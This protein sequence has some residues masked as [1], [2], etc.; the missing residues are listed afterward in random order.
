MIKNLT[1]AALAFGTISVSF[2]GSSG[3]K[4]LDAAPP[5][6]NV[7]DH[8]VVTD[9]GSLLRQP[10]AQ[11]D[12]PLVQNAR[13]SS[14]ADRIEQT[15]VAAPMPPA[16]AD[17]TEFAHFD[18]FLEPGQTSTFPGSAETIGRDIGGLRSWMADHNIG[19]RAIASASFVGNLLSTGQP[20]SPQRYNGQRPTLQLAAQNFNIAWGL[21]EFGLD[22]TKI[23]FGLNNTFTSYDA[24]GLDTTYIRTLAI[25]QSFFNGRLTIKAGITPNY[26]EYIGFY[27]G[28]SP[29][30]AAGIAGLLP[31]QAGLGADPANVP[32]IN[33]TAYGANGSYI[34]AGVQRSTSP[35][36]LN[37]EVRQRHGI[38]INIKLEDAGPLYIAEFGIR[39]PASAT[40]KQIWLRAGGFY[41]DS[42]YRRFDGEGTRSN[43][44]FYAL[45]DRQVTQPDPIVPARGIY[46]GA[47]AYLNPKS[48]NIST[49]SYEVRTF[50]IGMLPSRPR[51]TLALRATWTKFSKDARAANERIG[52]YA[53]KD[54]LN[55]TLSYSARVF[56]G[57]YVVPALSYIDHPSFVGDF[58]RALLT[59]VALVALF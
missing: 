55:V 8:L 30:L 41:N 38:G 25:Y 47:S 50:T 18:T 1:R 40:G 19:L 54:Q 49:Q 56:R 42:N 44:S 3:A 36:G 17:E 59:S 53:N 14:A 33:I 48:V 15:N 32:L 35:L 12:V 7:S 31:I 22:N 5:A 26:Y 9:V 39:R 11:Y 4:A 46:L 34:R 10:Q 58:K 27:V 6:S 45:A 13:K 23:L 20:R 24:N 21:N 29:I 51:D 57:F 16:N 43:A 52:L 37:E 28:G 2:V